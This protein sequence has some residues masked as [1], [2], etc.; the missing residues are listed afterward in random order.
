MREQTS[1]F[2]VAR[3]VTELSKMIGSRIRKAYQPHYE[4]VVLRM[5]KKGHANT[6]LVIV[7]GKRVYNST[8]DR[9][10][11]PNPSQFAMVLRKHLG[12]SRFIGVSQLGFD[13]VLSLEFE[14]GKGRMSLVIEL[15]RDG[16]VLLLDDSGIIV[17]PLTHA[18]YASRV[19]KK[20]VRYSPPPESLD[21]SLIHI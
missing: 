11:P 4:Q 19:L 14:H 10:M 16:N 17:Q 9:P 8:R 13:R 1:S 18:K 6:D 3:T 20:G 21:L 12:N 7:R 2:E 15:F 5:S